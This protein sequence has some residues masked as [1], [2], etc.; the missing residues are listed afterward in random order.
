MSSS[1]SVRPVRD[2]R[3]T[4]V[5]AIVV[6]IVLILAGGAAYGA[7]TLQ[8]RAENVTVSDGA[9]FLAGARVQDPLTAYAQADA[10]D[11]DALEATGGKT[12]AQLGQD[13]PAR[14]TART[15]S[16]L[17]ASLLTSVVAFG[18]S[19]IVAA[20]GLVFLFLGAAVRRLGKNDAAIVEQLPAAVAAVLADGSSRGPEPELAPA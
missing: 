11:R 16:F 5:F 2:V 4:G 6:G 7:V 19:L 18:V 17:R 10:I 13:D 1:A 20:S 12:Y 8:L 3:G 9:R 15:A 14:D